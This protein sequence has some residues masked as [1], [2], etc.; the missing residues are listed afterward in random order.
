MPL[1]GAM[2]QT[3]TEMTE[4]VELPDRL[5][6]RSTES[7]EMAEALE[8][9]TTNLDMMAAEATDAGETMEM[10]T[11]QE[12]TT[13]MSDTME[14][15]DMPLADTA[16]DDADESSLNDGGVSNSLSCRKRQRS[17]SET[18]D[19]SR[20][21]DLRGLMADIVT[22]TASFTSSSNSTLESATGYHHYPHH[23]H[24]HQYH[25]NAQFQ[26]QY[27]PPNMMLDQHQQN[28]VGEDR[29]ALLLRV[30]L[31]MKLGK[32]ILH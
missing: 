8:L 14:M 22:S 28:Q 3:N 6:R 11:T 1:N 29:A 2:L 17:G 12:D 15:S 13:E 30:Y 9:P 7:I 16:S 19:E 21:L 26:P 5:D 25:H 20:T 10:S 27:P 18:P 31:K 23:H 4:I 24:H 32:L